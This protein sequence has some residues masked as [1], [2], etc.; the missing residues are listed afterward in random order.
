VR[1]G[2]TPAAP[3][4]TA[5]SAAAPVLRARGDR[6][7]ACCLTDAP[8]LQEALASRFDISHHGVLVA[9]LLAHIDALDQA[10]GNI[11]ARI[12]IATAPYAELIELLCT[13]PGVGVRIAEIL[14]A[15]CGLDMSVFPTV[16]HLASSS[17]RRRGFGVMAMIRRTANYRS[18]ARTVWRSSPM[19]PAAPAMICARPPARVP[20][21]CSSVEPRR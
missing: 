1:R 6:G 20:T 17:P 5:P 3:L 10:I 18:S 7:R 9:G 8:Q 15:E 13:I 19:W 16:A 4:R 14:I 12:G 21:V 2:D 11:E